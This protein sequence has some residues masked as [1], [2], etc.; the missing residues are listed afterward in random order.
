M[1]LSIQGYARSMAL[2][3]RRLQELRDE[4]VRRVDL[5]GGRQLSAGEWLVRADALPRRLPISLALAW[6]VF[7]PLAY[8][9]E[10]SPA[11]RGPAP[12]WAVI[13]EL[14]FITT[15]V[16]AGMGLARRQ[17]MGLLASAGAAGLA[18]A[19]SVMCP[20]S[21]HHAATGAWWFAQ[22]GGFLAL[23]VASLAGLRTA[24]PRP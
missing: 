16:V 19:V 18:L 21:G 10:P 6:V 15:L 24:P 12:G 4:E 20:V 3:E 13:L 9:L 7:I 1:G 14:A 17:R 11:T 23:G 22:M 5:P 2:T 8:V